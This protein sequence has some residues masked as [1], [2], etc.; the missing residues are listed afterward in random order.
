MVSRIF[1]IILFFTAV[2]CTPRGR[3]ISINKSEIAPYTHLDLNERI[4]VNVPQ[5]VSQ[6][7]YRIFL[8]A[9]S[10]SVRQ[11]GFLEVW[12]VDE[13]ELELRASSI[14][15]FSLPRNIQR[16]HDNLGVSYF[17][18]IA[19]VSRKPFRYS[20]LSSQ[21]E[22][23]EQMIPGFMGSGGLMSETDHRV[24]TLYTL[25]QTDGAIKMAEFEVESSHLRN[26]TLDDRVIK[27]EI[28]EFFNQIYLAVP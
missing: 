14:A 20:S 5:N 23:R 16:L 10:L 11:R 1:F 9:A 8:E 21:V 27:R 2:S 4:L 3:I 19:I 22:Y 12:D 28:Q 17:L 13:Y 15:D 24:I 18:D 26:N 7:D 6:R 25:Y